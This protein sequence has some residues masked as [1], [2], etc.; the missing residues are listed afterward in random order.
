MGTDLFHWDGSSLLLLM[1][2][3]AL[4]YTANTVKNIPPVIVVGLVFNLVSVTTL[5][6]IP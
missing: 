3:V 4:H 5:E 2:I 6:G 1:L